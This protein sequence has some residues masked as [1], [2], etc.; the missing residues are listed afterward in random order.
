MRGL[1]EKEITSLAPTFLGP[2]A[3]AIRYTD[4]DG[5]IIKCTE[6]TGSICKGRVRKI[7]QIM[8]KLESRQRYD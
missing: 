6:I 5:K 1:V 2:I 8:K 3:R 4:T 7:I